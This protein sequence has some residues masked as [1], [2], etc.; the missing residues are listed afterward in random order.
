MEIDIEFGVQLVK[1]KAHLDKRE[2]YRES[3]PDRFSMLVDFSA[4]I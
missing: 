2:Q 3:V 1:N 4:K